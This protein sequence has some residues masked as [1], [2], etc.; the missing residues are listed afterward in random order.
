M[1]NFWHFALLVFITQSKSIMKAESLKR[2][3]LK[4]LGKG[5]VSLRPHI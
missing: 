3:C 4:R 5:F 2:Q 1:E